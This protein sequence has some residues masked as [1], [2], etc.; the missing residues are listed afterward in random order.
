MSQINYRDN[1]IPNPEDVRGLYNDAGW[2]V[3]TRDITK[4]MDGIKGSL[5]V[6]TAWD[7]KRLVGLIRVVG[8]GATILYI[9]DLIVL[10]SYKRQGIGRNL[11][12]RVREKY[13]SVWLT[14]LLTDD[15]VETRG[16]YESLGFKSC[17]RGELVSFVKFGH[18]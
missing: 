8:D 6:V 4:L 18:L 11:V 14:V 3:Y 1:L 9:Q 10:N 13:S 2:S 15:T 17:D 12:H 16:F 5:Y 7:R